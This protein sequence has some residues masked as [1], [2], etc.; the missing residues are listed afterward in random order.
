MWVVLNPN[1]KGGN[2]CSYARQKETN[3]GIFCITSLFS[4]LCCNWCREEGKAKK[5][6]RIS[7]AGELRCVSCAMV[8]ILYAQS[9]PCLPL[10][11]FFCTE[12]K[13]FFPLSIF[14]C[15]HERARATREEGQMLCWIDRYGAGEKIIFVE[16]PASESQPLTPDPPAYVGG[17][18]Y[19]GTRMGGGM[20]P[21][22]TQSSH[23]CCTGKSTVQW[24][25]MPKKRSPNCLSLSQPPNQ[26]SADGTEQLFGAEKGFSVPYVLSRQEGQRWAEAFRS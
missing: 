14:S 4:I 8:S 10:V 24:A 21:A 1:I 15:K 16:K 5:G 23:C 20:E 22:H 25:A 13:L 3:C 18:P 19:L 17:G 12:S 6:K 26:C 2:D 9:S 7:L 11:N